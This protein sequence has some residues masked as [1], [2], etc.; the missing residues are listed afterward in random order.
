MPLLTPM[1]FSD[2][3]NDLGSLING[4]YVYSIMKLMNKNITILIHDYNI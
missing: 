1:V 4:D 2:G 3:K